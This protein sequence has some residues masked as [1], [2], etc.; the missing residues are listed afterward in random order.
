M[1]PDEQARLTLVGPGTPMGELYRRYW[2]PVLASSEL[3]PGCSRAVR[4][5]GED[6]IAYR[7]TGNE[8]GLVCERCPHRGT[9]LRLGIVDGE[10]I[11][12]PYHGWKFNGTGQ[13]LEMPAEAD[14]VRLAARIRTTAYGIAELGGFIF[15]YLGPAPAPLL[16]RYDLYVWGNVLRD[17]GRAVLPC[18][19]LQIMENSVDPTHTEWL[20]GNH[21][22]AMLPAE[23]QAATVAYARHQVRIGFERFRYGITKRRMLEGGS[24]SDE[25][26]REGHPLIFPN[27]LRVGVQGQH[28]FQIRVPV[29]DTHTLHWWY[30][31]YRPAPGRQAPLQAEVPLYEVPWR[32]A[33]GNFIVD[34]VDGGDMMVWVSQGAIADRT[35]ETLVSSDRGLLLLRQMYVEA[36][37]QVRM[38]ADPLGVI[39]DPVENQ[40]IEFTQEHDKFGDG[41]RFLQQALSITHV[42]YSPMRAQIRALLD[43][44]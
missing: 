39:R 34:Y 28:R 27:M 16:P 1:T 42:R 20:H 32:D 18:N 43:L 40:L 3:R 22:R 30:S 37:E 41:R 15:A 5:L 17:I 29:D 2:L 33:E 24:E 9:S 19:W 31:V 36:L 12:C 26:W 11:R 44:D 10:G 38:G 6:L 21:L 7:T 23:Q 13:C 8:L 14:S 35:R 25:D 4:L